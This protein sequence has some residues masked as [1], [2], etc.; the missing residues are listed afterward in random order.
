MNE[1]LQYALAYALRG[2][3]LALLSLDVDHFKRINDV[4]GRSVGDVVLKEIAA[5]LQK[6]ARE[7]DLVARYGGDSFVFLYTDVQRPANIAALAERIQEIV[8]APCIN[9]EQSISTSI[10]IGISLAPSDAVDVE[11]LIKNSHIALASAKKSGRKKYRFFE[12]QMDSRVREC[13]LLETDLREALSAEEFS[14]FYQPIVD[15]RSS[16]VSSV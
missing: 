1:R 6:C 11:R 16:Q 12:P 7:T 8:S 3:G 13:R 15:I 10:S 5:R 2:Q 9:G 4:H 14:V